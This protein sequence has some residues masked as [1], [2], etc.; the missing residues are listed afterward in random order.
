MMR[1]SLT[2]A[3]TDFK[4]ALDL[5]FVKMGL[6]LSAAFGPV[7][8]ILMFVSLVAVIPPSEMAMITTLLGPM[9]PAFLGIF[10]IIPT[11]MISANAL[12]GER[13]MNTL[14][15]L[16]CTPLTDRELLW[17]KTMAGVIPSLIILVSSTIVS[18]VV[19]AVL[20]V[21]MGFPMVIILD[22]SG[23]FLL[24]TS[25]P[26]MIFAVVA[27]MIIISGRVTR[28]YEAYQMTT[29]I[30][31]VFMIPMIMPLMGMETGMTADLAWFSNII[32]LIIAAL[33]FVI[34]WALA[35]KLFNRD[36]LVSMV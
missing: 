22:L 21:A 24:S 19:V 11:T 23:V 9:V 16:L 34:G 6:I 3:K 35:L 18:V 12:V 27:I 5:R 7:M 30:I 32:T 1:K 20:T 29:V 17:G 2:V 25:V 8:I 10:A 14:E 15:P 28:V 36:K 13:E 33:V 4:N 26:L 31:V